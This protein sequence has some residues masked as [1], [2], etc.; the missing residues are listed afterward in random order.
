MYNYTPFK[1]SVRLDL[2]PHAYLNLFRLCSYL[3]PN[4]NLFVPSLSLKHYKFVHIYILGIAYAWFV[5]KNILRYVK[6]WKLML[7]LN[8]VFQEIKSCW[9]TAALSCRWLQLLISAC[10]KY[11]CNSRS[12]SAIKSPN[13][14]R[15]KPKSTCLN[16]SPHYHFQLA[17]SQSSLKLQSHT[18]F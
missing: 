12:N 8:A 9:S 6:H 15:K 3:Y 16:I 11:Y 5:I 7:V 2:S 17:E 18:H 13:L 1:F 14:N 10:A 4:L